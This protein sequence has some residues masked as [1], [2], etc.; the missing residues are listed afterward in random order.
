ME[1]HWDI[2]FRKNPL[3]IT[4]HQQYLPTELYSSCWIQIKQK[5]LTNRFLIRQKFVFA[6]FPDPRGLILRPTKWYNSE[7]KCCCSRTDYCRGY[8]NSH[9]KEMPTPPLFFL[10]SLFFFYSFLLS[11]LPQPPEVYGIFNKT[12]C[13]GR[14]WN[15][16][17]QLVA[18]Y[19]CMCVC[20]LYP[21]DSKSK[22]SYRGLASCHQ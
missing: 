4:K 14:F 7:W 5:S 6:L 10:P 20:V 18:L 11:S 9:Y 15:T 8:R 13:G 16:S 12:T 1:L 3:F 21:R 22:L 17:S 19:V 2:V